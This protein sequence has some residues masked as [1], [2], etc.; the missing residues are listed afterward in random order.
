[1]SYQR[2]GAA[3]G[4]LDLVA[5]NIRQTPFPE[6]WTNSELFQ[7]TAPGGRLSRQVPRLQYRKVCGGCRARAYALTGDLAGG[8]P[9]L[10]V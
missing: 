2:G 10:P 1:V 6:I 7:P 3:C 5:G 9:H 4:Y 8:R